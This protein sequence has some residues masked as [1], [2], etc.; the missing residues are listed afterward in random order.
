LR[1]SFKNIASSAVYGDTGYGV[2]RVVRV[3]VENDSRGVFGGAEM[4]KSSIAGNEEEAKED[5]DYEEQC[6]SYSYAYYLSE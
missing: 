5:S 1:F 4:G 2:R 3:R 6:G